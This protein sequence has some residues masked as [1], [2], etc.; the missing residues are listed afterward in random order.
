MKMPAGS[1]IF[2]LALLIVFIM[3]CSFM[4]SNMPSFGPKPTQ[5]PL[6]TVPALVTPDIVMPGGSPTES[7]PSDSSGVSPFDDIQTI[8]FVGKEFELKFKSLDQPVQTFEYYLP[9]ESPS[10]WL[11]LVEIQYYPVHPT[12]NQPVEF[13]QRIADAFMQQYPDMQYSLLTNNNTNEAMLNFF[14]PTATRAGYLEFN[15]FK[16]LKDPGSSRVIGFHYAKNIEDI[17]ASRSHDDV[18]AEIRQTV[19]DIEAALAKFN[20]FEQ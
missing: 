4:P 12:A 6:A 14:Y 9:N 20:L 16:F 7:V 10:D 3:G 19:K 8:E 2:L 17:S 15:A 11:E 13:A 1:K 18:L 5:P